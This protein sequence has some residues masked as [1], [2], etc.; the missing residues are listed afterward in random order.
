M[1]CQLMLA[2]AAAQGRDS[3]DKQQK[4]PRLRHRA[5]T[6]FVLREHVLTTNKVIHV[7]GCE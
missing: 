6:E 5:E 4:T 2:T 1:T 3:S 7:N